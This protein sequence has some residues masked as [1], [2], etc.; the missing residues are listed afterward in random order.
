MLNRRPSS[1][2]KTHIAYSVLWRFWYSFRLLFIGST[3][4]LVFALGRQPVAALA[5]EVVTLILCVLAWTHSYRFSG[6]ARV[7]TFT[8]RKAPTERP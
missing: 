5:T 2:R 8:K 6:T 7:V 3:I 4:A 1:P